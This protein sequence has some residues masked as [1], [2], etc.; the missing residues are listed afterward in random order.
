[1]FKLI[2]TLWFNQKSR[3][4][5]IQALFLF[6]IGYIGFKLC[7]NVSSHLKEHEIAFGFDF[8]KDTAGFSILMHLIDYNEQSSYARAFWVGLL[9][10]L[11]VAMLSIVFATLLGLLVGIA[12]VSKYP[13]VATI[14][15]LYVE[16]IRNIPLLLQI[17]FWYF[18]VLRSAP[19]PNNS[20]SLFDAIHITN[21]GIYFPSVSSTP[22][23][24][25]LNF[26]GGINLIP[27]FLALFIALSV[28]T[29][30]YIAEIVRMG[31]LAIPKGQKE[32][33]QSL[34]LT[35]M[36]SLKL[37][38]FPQA[39]KIM[40]PSLTNQYLNCVKNSSLAVAIAYPDLVNVF[41]GT[42]L[43]QTGHSV[44]IILITMGVYLSISLCISGMVWLYERTQKWS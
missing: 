3:S 15:K 41:S 14:G 40:L 2:E 22:M 26:E 20:I 24:N 31:L 39:L 13:I 44:E 37:I 35:S 32:A 30:S 8:L 42:V 23:F 28:Y 1:M 36:Q 16:I 17:F 4:L 7:S 34:G 6:I 11:F 18:V 43:N 10:T 5:I 29:A 25:G 33:A 12:R 19:L 9:N 27:E 21:R 38:I